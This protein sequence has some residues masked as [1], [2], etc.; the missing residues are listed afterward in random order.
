MAVSAVHDQVLR[1]AIREHPDDG[2]EAATYA[3]LTREVARLMQLPFE[4][5][6]DD[7][8]RGFYVPDDT[9]TAAQ[10][11][12]LGLR[13][14][15]D[16]LGGVV[17]YAFVATKVIT[18]PLVDAHAAAPQGWQHALGGA[19]VDATVPGYAAFARED[20]LQAYA[21][22]CVGGRVRLKLPTGVGGMGQ[23]LLDDGKALYEALDALGPDYLAQHGV[24][25]ERHLERP[26]TFSVGQ[27]DC[28]GLTIA[29]YGTQTTTRDRDGREAYG[30][31]NLFVIRGTLD[32]LL[33]GELAPDH[34]QA[35]T[36]ARV[37]DQFISRA[38]PDFY[39]SR[40]NYD[41]IEGLDRDGIRLSGVLEQSW[42][43]GGATPAE[44]AAVEAFLR[45]PALRTVAACT[46][47][48]YDDRP[49]PAD[50][51]VYYRGEDARAGRLLKYRQVL[52]TG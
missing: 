19:L 24:V 23:R 29:Y 14:A 26:V 10:A 39:A 6:A 49:A 16:L 42:R 50:A 52:G 5:D 41:V 40:R 38:Y 1:H 32:D 47:E 35:V 20:A 28:A 2:H 45:D 33:A 22:L 27:V 43:I 48:F 7:G 13:G 36:K 34:R 3:W 17:P 12:R 11:A 44:L 30:G 31:S 15:C 8:G 51:Q 18:H 21:R 4:R 46:R 37:Y 25:L 9:L